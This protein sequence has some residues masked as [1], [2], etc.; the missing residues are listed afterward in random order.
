MNYTYDSENH[1]TSGTG[2]GKTIM[3]VYDASGNFCSGQSPALRP[4]FRDHA[5]QK[6]PKSRDFAYAVN[7]PFLLRQATQTRFAH[8]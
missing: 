1:M 7:N 4:I 5:N 2:D 6:V 3:M 8:T